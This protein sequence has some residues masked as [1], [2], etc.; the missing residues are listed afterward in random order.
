LKL[1]EGFTRL[2]PVAAVVV[3]YS[4]SFFLLSK[5]LT[6]DV[7]LGVVYAIWSAAGVALIVVIDA[8]WFDHR[9]STLQ[10]VGLCLVVAGVAALQSGAAT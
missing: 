1:S 8:L 9:L 4:A 2:G 10:I 5:I 3:G 6:R 7:S